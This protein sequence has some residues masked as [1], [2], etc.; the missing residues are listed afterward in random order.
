MEV[1]KYKNEYICAYDVASE[2]YA[3]NYELKKK[4]KIA[5]KNGELTCPDCGKEVILKANDLKKKVPHF[6]H[7]V[8][9]L[10]C[11][12]ISN[13]ARESEEHK[14]GRMLLYQYMKSLYPNDALMIKYRFK[15]RRIADIYIEFSN[16]NKL[17]IEF[18]RT[19]LTLEEWQEREEEYNRLN[20]NVLWILRGK[21]EELIGRKQ[22]IEVP[23]FKQIMLNERNKLAVF[24]DVEKNKFILMK[25]MSYQD[26]YN[27]KNIYDKV[28]SVA[29][30]M[31]DVIIKTD[32]NIVCDFFEKYNEEFKEFINECIKDCEA[33]EKNRL[34]LE[35]IKNKQ[36]E[37]EKF[38]QE[39]IKEKILSIKMNN[40]KYCRRHVGYW[41]KFIDAVN[42]NDKFITLISNWL[43]NYN[44]SKNL[45]ST[46]LILKYFYIIGDKKALNVYT[47][48]MQ[49]LDLNVDINLFYQG[50]SNLRCPYCNGELEKMYDDERKIRVLS[51]ENF[52]KCKFSFKVD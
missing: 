12:S 16:G 43:R 51:C 4:L 44:D 30:K 47:K 1:C 39:K 42:G 52:P 33:K 26:K 36:L 14:R 45:E 17:A 21:E 40:S 25:N 2:N 27:D 38:E 34:L 5:G 11:D 31:E 19:D 8:T 46:I 48:I 3:L 18:Q 23:F 10:K 41:H 13:G 24:L 9:D 50:D 6:S 28:V 22:Q 7:K 32:G 15:N 37:E 35:E 29:Y 20:V 49:S